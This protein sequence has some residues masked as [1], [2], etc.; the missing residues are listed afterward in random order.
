MKITLKNSKSIR[1]L[2]VI[3]VLTALYAII[4]FLPLTHGESIRPMAWAVFLLIIGVVSFCIGIITTVANALR[5]RYI[6]AILCFLF[7]I[8]PIP[9]AF[10]IVYIFIAMKG[11]K[12]QP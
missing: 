7:S 6:N 3:N 9:L 1:A 4:T 10:I 12:I 8:T 5:R 11:L 2:L